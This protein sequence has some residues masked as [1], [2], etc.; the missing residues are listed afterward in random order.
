MGLT[1]DDIRKQRAMLE[2]CDEIREAK[3][4]QSERQRLRD[5]FAAAALAGLLAAPTDKDRSM[6]Y[7]ARLAYEAADAMLRERARSYEQID[8]NRGVF[9]TNLDATPVARAQLSSGD[10]A[11]SGGGSDRNDKPAPRP[12]V[13][14]GDIP[15]SRTRDIVTRLRKWC[16][17]VD[18]ESAQDLMDEAATEI[19][20]LRI[21]SH[22]REAIAA[23]AESV[24]FDDD[25]NWTTLHEL[26]ERTK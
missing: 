5:H 26:L 11:S 13:G 12:A 6:D 1:L 7:W 16:H 23:A 3:Q 20:R 17:A 10:H 21:R 22:E 9:N 24:K 14:T 8:E 19:E 18:A 2:R 15:D 25:S 4:Q